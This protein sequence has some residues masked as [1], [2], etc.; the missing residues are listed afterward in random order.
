MEEEHMRIARSAGRL[1][2]VAVAA[3]LALLPMACG[4]DGPTGGGGGTG[5]ASGVVRDETESGVGGVALSMVRSGHVTQ[6]RTSGSGGDYSFV[7]LASGG[8][9]LQFTLPAGYTLATGQNNPVTVQIQAGATT[10][11]PAIRLVRPAATG[12]IQATVTAGGTPVAGAIVRARPD[13]SGTIAAQ[14]TTSAGGT[15][16][17]S[18][19]AAGS[20]EV[21]LTAPA[22]YALADGE[23]GVKAVAVTAN[24]TANVAFALV[25]VDEPLQ[26]IN[27]TAGNRFSPEDVEITA[28]TRVRWVNEMTMLHTITPDNTGQTGVWARAVLQNAGET[29]EHVFTVAGQTYTYHCE[30]H[31]GEGMVG[32]IVVVAP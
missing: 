11:V 28:G 31:Q 10:T 12:S 25:E 30:P 19:L 17:L 7:D 4:S 24:A 26:I 13:G 32:R 6:N 2:A 23:M 15:A 29:F 16:T 27:L 14:G 18:G 9:S 20:Y 22:G 3:S 8:W 21:E 1:G 5:N